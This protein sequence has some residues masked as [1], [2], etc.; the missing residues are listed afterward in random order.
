ML[1]NWLMKRF[2]PCGADLT[3]EVER[4]FAKYGTVVTQGTHGLDE[5]FSPVL[6]LI[7]RLRFDGNFP[8]VLYP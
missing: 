6:I 1:E 7:L 8:I 5:V 3:M 2:R 4:K